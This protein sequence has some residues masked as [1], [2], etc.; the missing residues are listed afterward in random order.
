MA[1]TPASTQHAH[2]F[3]RAIAWILGSFAFLAGGIVAGGV[4]VGAL[5]WIWPAA[6]FVGYILVKQHG[7]QFWAPGDLDALWRWAP[8]GGFPGAAGRTGSPTRGPAEDA[9]GPQKR[10]PHR[11]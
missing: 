5:K 9:G 8:P 3:A 1:M 2:G 11:I 4:A 10:G 7:L 6:G